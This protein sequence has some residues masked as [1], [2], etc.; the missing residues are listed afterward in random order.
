MD[1]L[2]EIRRL[3]KRLEDFSG[4]PDADDWRM[5]WRL[6]SNDIEVYATK[7]FVE[8]S[9]DYVTLHN[10]VDPF[11]VPS[12]DD[13]RDF[14]EDQGADVYEAL[15][16]IEHRLE[17]K[18]AVLKDEVHTENVIPAGMPHS[19][20]AL[21][22]DL[23]EGAQQRIWIADPWMDRTIFALLS[24][25]DLKVN[26]RLLTRKANLPGDFPNE[27]TLFVKQ[28]SRDCEAQDGLGDQH[29]R[30]LIVDDRTFIT[31]AS[32]KDLGKKESV[33]TELRD[34]KDAIVSSFESRWSSGTPL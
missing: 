6:L 15:R 23:V 1:P 25:A 9:K 18:Q 21:L 13:W 7:S 22:R 19:A 16:L 20:Y 33:V 5:T 11:M 4:M 8:G 17:R 3:K 24:N 27:L 10:A 34:V 14:L 29:D 30:Y 2:A 26:L 28:G 32:L 12:M 31:G